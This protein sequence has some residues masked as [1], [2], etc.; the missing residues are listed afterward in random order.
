MK[1]SAKFFGSSALLVTF[2]AFSSGSRYWINQRA[3]RSLET[4]YTLS[5]RA[6]TTVSQLESTLQEE[7]A[8]LNRLVV[9]P[10]KDTEITYYRQQHRAFIETLDAFAQTADKDDLIVQ[11]QMKTI[12]KQHRYLEELASRAFNDDISERQLQGLPRSLEAFEDSLKIYT[13]ALLKH[14]EAQAIDDREQA[15]ERYAQLVWLEVLSFSA[16]VLMLA[17]QYRY[18]VRPAGRSLPQ[19]G[20]DRIVSTVPSK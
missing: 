2:V 12:R 13:Q 11:A 17:L 10:E 18:F 9:L 6:N 4:S 20:R 16:I 3:A 14:S 7:L 5:Q 1:I 8:S 19:K 15:D